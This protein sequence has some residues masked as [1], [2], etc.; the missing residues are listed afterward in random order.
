MPAPAL[1]NMVYLPMLF[2]SGNLRATQA[3]PSTIQH[4]GSC[5]LPITTHSWHGRRSASTMSHPVRAR[6]AGRFGRRALHADRRLYRLDQDKEVPANQPAPAIRASHLRGRRPRRHRAPAGRG[7]RPSPGWGATVRRFTLITSPGALVRLCSVIP[8]M[9][10][11][12]CWARPSRGCR[13]RRRC[14]RVV[15]D[16]EVVEKR[17]VRVC[18]SRRAISV[19]VSGACSKRRL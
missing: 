3:T 6:L 14:R 5:C 19:A 15:H 13:S 4:I 16:A 10:S 8:A 1:A 2:L 9:V 7:A 17:S 11:D 18:P 12:S